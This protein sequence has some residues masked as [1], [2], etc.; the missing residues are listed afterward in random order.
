MKNLVIG[1][2]AHVDAGKTTLSEA[3][4]YKT[5]VIKK[6]GRVDNQDAHLDTD[7]QEK[8]RGIT[9]FSKQAIFELPHFHVTLVDTPGHV[10]FSAEMERTLQVL[11]YAVLVVSAPGGVDS[12]T[13]ALFRLLN[14]YKI[15]TVIF[16]NKMDQYMNDKETIISEL[17]ERLSERCVD[18]G[19][20]KQNDDG[21]LEGEACEE[22]SVFSDDEEIINDYLRYGSMDKELIGEIIK[23]QKV[24][25]C[26][27]GAAL[28][29]HGVDELLSMMDLFFAA[30]DYDDTFGARV[31]KITRDEKGNRLTHMKLTGGSLALRTPLGEN[32]EK[33][34]ELRIYNGAKYEAVKEVHAGE[35]CACLG[36]SDTQ[37]GSGIGKESDTDFCL[38]APVIRYSMRLPDDISA[39][40]VYPEI[41]ALSEELPE[42]DCTWNESLEEIQV[43]LMGQVQLEILTELVMVRLGFKP[44]FDTGRIT[45][46]ETVANTVIGVG[47]FEPLRHYAE[48]HIR[49]EPGERGS[50]IEVA[51]DVSED[52]LDKNW[53]RLIMYHLREKQHRGVLTGSPLTDVRLTVTGG[54]AHPKHTEGGDFRKA[55][56]RAVRMGLMYAENV[57]LEPYYDFY[58]ELP[59]TMAGRAIR[60]LEMCFAKLAPPEFVGDTAVITGYGPVATIVEYQK[61][62]SAHTGGQGSMSVSLRGYDVCHDQE[63][64]LSDNTY[65]P[66][67]DLANPTSS[68]F[69]AHGAGYIVPWYEVRDHM[70][71]Q[72]EDASSDPVTP[73][74]PIVKSGSFDYTID[75]E[76]I[77]SIIGRVQSANANKKK[78]AYKKQHREQNAH[79]KSGSSSQKV[80]TAPRK[81]KLLIVDGFNVIYAWS[82]LKD[83]LQVNVDA[84]KSKLI[85]I[86]SNYQGMTDAEVLVVFDGYRV[87]G[88]T[89]SSETNGSITVIHT[90]EGQTADAFIERFAHDFKAK[91]EITVASSDGLIQTV[92]RGAGAYIISSKDLETEINRLEN[93]FRETYNIKS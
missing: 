3:I 73:A 52:V 14:E 43:M 18:F 42:L 90:K 76:E 40:K 26:V 28:K 89:G 72:D 34:S 86:L 21:Y 19:E 64:A 10:D 12:H 8:R 62:L 39:R 79:E 36:L 88:N 75:L 23:E 16:V 13:K 37:A 17:K 70:H 33:V 4:L 29:T 74:R 56:I 63:A 68:V 25:P 2:L 32:G 50:G 35:V 92:V 58:L 65:D 9:I 60:E 6:L 20:F 93:N 80:T 7:V 27:C 85:D 38:I 59:Q 78:S 83:V 55:T 49:I 46:K 41:C 44:R 71:V 61:E 51:S 45:Y 22:I 81:E 84:A 67:A 66:E 77:D 87:K 30:P 82:S 54:R 53:Q 47:H 69:C 48:V 5:E 91:Y 15:P 31:F 11:D 1:I 57:L 24:F